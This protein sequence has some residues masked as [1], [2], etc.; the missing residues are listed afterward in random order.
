MMSHKLFPAVV[1]SALWLMLPESAAA[2]S[3]IAGIVKDSSGAV[4]PGVTVEAASPALIEKTRTVVTD[5]AGQYKIIDLRPGVYTVTVSLGGFTTIKREGI[6]LTANFTASVNADMKL[7]GLEES[8]TVSGASPIVDVQT[9][10]QRDVLTRDVLDALPTGRNYQT[11]G[12]TLPGVSM[13]RFDVGGS[14]AMQQSTVITAGSV[15]GDM[16]ILVDGMNISSSLSS[17][18]VPAV[19]HNDGAYQEYVYQVKVFK[20]K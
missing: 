19:Y 6:E 12:A 5:S 1:M 8:I 11:I 3:A 10:Q 9:A 18:S 2:Q 15:G 17:G 4:L 7:G 13:G 14:T 16:A 20:H